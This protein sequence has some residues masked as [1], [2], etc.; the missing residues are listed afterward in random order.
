MS[1]CTRLGFAKT[2]KTPSALLRAFLSSIAKSDAE[3]GS[4]QDT[5]NQEC[6]HLV[7]VLELLRAVM[8]AAG[9]CLTTLVR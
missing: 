4:P 1:E 3:L 5:A 9:I 8:I 6:L 2:R 7:C